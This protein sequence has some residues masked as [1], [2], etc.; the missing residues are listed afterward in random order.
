MHGEGG[1][2]FVTSAVDALNEDMKFRL[3]QAIRNFDEFDGG[4]DPYHQHDFGK[5]ELEGTAYYFKVD[6]YDL[7]LEYA[8]DDP[9]NE[10]ITRRVMTV[11]RA[12]EY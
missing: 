4:N 12:D 8:S 1:Q 3:I 10:L 6:A 7:S 9:A 11:L 2:I 5:V